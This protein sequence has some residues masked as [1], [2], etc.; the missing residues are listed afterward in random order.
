[1]TPGI[2]R[3]DVL[4]KLCQRPRRWFA[5]R[6]EDPAQLDYVDAPFAGLDLGD[7]AMGCAES[8]RKGALRKL[9]ALAGRF[10]FRPDEGV[11]LGMRRFFH[12]SDYR[13]NVE[14]SQIGSN[15]KVLLPQPATRGHCQWK[16]SS[17]WCQRIT[18]PR[19]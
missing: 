13:G 11:F 17:S 15:R 18:V 16:N 12:C 4:A 8:R 2:H 6:R 7:P 1:M 10:Q 19:T 14:C 5:A 9:R 3:N